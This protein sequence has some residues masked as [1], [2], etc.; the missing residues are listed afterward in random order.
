MARRIALCL[1]VVMMMVPAAW[2]DSLGA[3]SADCGQAPPLMSVASPQVPADAASLEVLNPLKDANFASTSCCT[4]QEID[5]CYASVEPG[6]GCY[7]ERITC[8]YNNECW[9]QIF[10]Y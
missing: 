10:C 2:A 7:V 5:H 6:S 3:P 8:W 4:Q 9:C 1:A